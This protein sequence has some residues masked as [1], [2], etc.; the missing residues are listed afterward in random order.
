MTQSPPDSQ[1]SPAGA[2]LDW[3]DPS[4]L[5]VAEVKELFVVLGKALRAHQLYDENNPVYQRFVS[6]L[7]DSL[8]GLWGEMDRV[9]IHVEEDRFTWMA[10]EVYRSTSRTDSLAFL[11]FKDGVREFTILEGLETHELTTLLQVLNRARDLRPEG[12]DLLTVLW[13]QDLQYFT[14]TYVDLLAEGLDIPEAGEGFAQ[15]FHQVIEQ[16][17]G[18]GEEGEEGEEE[19]GGEEGGAPPPSQVS[20]EDFNPTLYS[21]DPKEKE[22]IEEE[23]QT[24]MDRDLRGDVLAALFDRVEEPRFPARQG[25]ILEVFR[26]LLPNLLSR[27]ALSSAGQVVEEVSRLLRAEGAL[28][29]EQIEAANKILDEVSGADTLRELVQALEDGT[30][31]PNPA[32]LAALLRH[33]RAGALEPLLRCAEEAE[34]KSIKAIIQEAVKGIADKYREALIGCMDS[35]DPVVAA[36]ACSLAGKMQLTEAGPRVATLLG[37]DSPRVRMAA[38]EAAVEMKASTTAGA[39]QEALRDPDREV[40]IAAARGLGALRYR[41]AAPYFREAIE[42]KAIRQADISEQIAFFESYGLLQEPDAVKFLDALLNG[43]GFLGR[44]ESGE[45]RACAAL[46]LGKMG[47]DEARAALEKASAEQDPVVRSAVGR[48]LRGEA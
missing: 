10:E 30:I 35:Q 41:P 34:D 6:Q 13:E 42:G 14:Y 11:L 1:E 31:S 15:G 8:R 45:I 7:G 17:M 27:G 39:L 12:D 9:Q 19:A 48:A 20:S 3:D 22:R 29:E 25:E 5:P 21:L 18:E 32:E 23:I 26:I 28:Q 40:R 43:K 44:K 36:G 24:E 46:G 2:T 47:T 16:E 37:H 33:M 4:T 38:V